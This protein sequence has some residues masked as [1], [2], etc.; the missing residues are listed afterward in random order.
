MAL[1]AADATFGS[2]VNAK[3]YKVVHCAGAIQGDGIN[4]YMLAKVLDA[5]LEAGYSAEVGVLYIG[6]HKVY[7]GV[8]LCT[9]IHNWGNS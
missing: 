9:T 5:V 4:I 3:G 1:Q 7:I 8:H 2:T 6:V